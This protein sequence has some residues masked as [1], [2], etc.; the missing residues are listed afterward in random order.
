MSSGVKRALFIFLKST[1]IVV[2]GLLSLGFIIGLFYGAEIKR[3]MLSQ[4]NEHLAT[5]IK[6][7]EFHFSV[8]RHFPYASFDMEEVMTREVCDKKEKDTLLYAG[9]ISL[10]FNIMSVFDKNIAVKKV[11]VKDGYANIHID[12]E[13]KN[14][15]HF[16]K[17]KPDS[18]AESSSVNVQLISLVNMRV[19]YLNEHDNQDYLFTSKE[20]VL[21]GKFSDEKFTLNTN[22]KLHVSHL[23]INNVNYVADK[24]V[25]I[26]SGLSVN[27]VTD[28]YRFDKSSVQIAGL[29]FDVEGIVHS[30]KANTKIDL[31]VSSHE[32]DMEAFISMLPPVYV[33]TFSSYKSTGKFVFKSTIRGEVSHTTSPEVAFAFGIRD[34]SLSPESRDISLEKLNLTGTYINHGQNGKDELVIPAL[35]ALL[36][37]H[38][39]KAD[40]RVSDLRNPYLSLNA[41]ANLDLSQLQHFI[42][43]DTLESLSGEMNLKIAFAGKIKDIPAMNSGQTYKVKASGVI[44]MK[45]VAFQLKRNPLI[46]KNIN[47]N[48]TLQDNDIAVNSLSGNISSSDLRLSGRFNNFINFILIPNQ[49]ALFNARLNSTMLDLDELMANKATTTQGDTS[50]I[51]KFNPRLVSDLDVAVA[52]IKFRQFRASRMN[53]KIHLDHQVITGKG[54]TFAAMAGMVYM[55]ATIN[56]ARKDSVFMKFDSKISRLDITKLFTQMENFGQTTMTDK[57]VKGSVSADV[58]FSSAWSV[59]LNIDE[60]KVRSTCDITIDNGELN[61]FT[62]ILALSKYL[63]VPDL[64]HIRFSTL[65]NQI[66]ISNRVISI[67]SMVINSSALNLTASGTHNF[68]NIVD[69]SLRL[70]LSDILGKKMQTTSE[71]GEIEDDGLGRTQ[72]LI[73]M[74]GPVDNPRFGYDRKGAK[75]KIKNDIVKEKQN[76]KGILKEEFGMFRKDTSRVESR[77][78]KEELQIDWS[79]SE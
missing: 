50:Y 45:N 24:P 8:I 38:P 30:E 40:L 22:A 2:L 3:V 11:L 53:G 23:F 68:D 5:E 44:D 77:K 39:I 13:G 47:G 67:P 63:K 72:L 31:A 62:P 9:K 70:M 49:P 15:Y 64:N 71:F 43:K 14:N 55:D 28:D 34:G 20:S 48:F 1:A 4:L 78:K 54:L 73:S 26:H 21:S 76:L 19:R 16:W 56:A 32:A 60:G 57:N 79:S 7:K 6:V 37:G 65:K 42:K 75:E 52:N 25:I 74:K 29:L 17:S 51:L 18:S 27:T 46:F 33:K 58:Q 69:Y 66:S 35:S 59:D 12:A 36:G 41:S 61:N 10:L